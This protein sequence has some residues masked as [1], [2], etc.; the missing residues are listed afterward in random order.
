MLGTG[1]GPSSQ[2]TGGG[3]N[4]KRNGDDKERWDVVRCEVMDVLRGGLNEKKPGLGLDVPT[5]AWRMKVSLR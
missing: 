4:V 2:A 1:K 3:C 5:R